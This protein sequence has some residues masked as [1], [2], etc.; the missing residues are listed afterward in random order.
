MGATLGNLQ[1]GP[2]WTDIFLD[3]KQGDSVAISLAEESDSDSSW[4]CVVRVRSEHGTFILGSFRTISP[5]RG[6]PPARCVAICYFPGAV[7]WLTSWRR[8][9]GT[10]PNAAADCVLS[11]RDCCSGTLPG[12]TPLL[13]GPT[14]PS[15][16]RTFVRLPSAPAGPLLAIQ[17][18][19]TAPA[20]NLFSAQ[21]QLENLALAGPNFAMLF[22]QA[23]AP[24]L[25]DTPFWARAIGPAAAEPS[26]A[27]FS[28][29]VQGRPSTSLLWAAVSTT[30]AHFTPS[31]ALI[32]V[33]AELAL[34]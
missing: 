10:N 11:S 22:D 19:T 18:L 20:A 9:S 8:V 15:A 30:L 12:V 5:A 4:E 29:G 31:G 16:P 17:Q 14:G 32:D 3:G 21:I 13:F 26:A 27:I 6:Q 25:G 33:S 7:Q 28:G 23:A 24:A 2:L 1:A 34:P